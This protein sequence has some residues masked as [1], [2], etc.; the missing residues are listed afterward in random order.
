[1]ESMLCTLSLEL[2]L[3]SRK[4]GLAKEPTDLVSDRPFTD[5]P[6]LSFPLM[7]KEENNWIS[8]MT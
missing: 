8:I 5:Q 6:C 2:D 3:R 7:L 4:E 1:M